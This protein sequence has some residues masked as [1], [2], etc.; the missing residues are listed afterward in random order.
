MMQ[1]TLIP[2]KA[3]FVSKFIVRAGIGLVAA[4]CLSTAHAESDQQLLTQIEYNIGRAI[5][6]KDPTMLDVIFGDDFFSYSG[7]PNKRTK[8]DWIANSVSPKLVITQF[9]YSPFDIRIFG[10]TAIVQGSNDDDAKYEGKNISGTY[11]WLDVF[12]KREGRWKL[13]AN[14]TVTVPEG[15]GRRDGVWTTV[16][17]QATTGS[18]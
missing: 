5:I 12:V 10:T 8:Q 17:D 13:I 16:T 4:A 11:T 3:F 6:K 7:E 15:T 18:P 14:E 9:R 1:S 2:H